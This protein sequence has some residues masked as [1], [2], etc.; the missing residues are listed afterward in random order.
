MEIAKERAIL[1]NSTD[2][3][4]ALSRAVKL[5]L[6]QCYLPLLNFIIIMGT[7]N[8]IRSLHFLT[9][10]QR[11]N[12]RNHSKGDG[13]M[14]FIQTRYVFSEKIGGDCGKGSFFKIIVAGSQKFAKFAIMSFCEE[15][16]IRTKSD[17]LQ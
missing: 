9:N 17:C 16:E 10:T 8:E 5:Q 12:G 11:Y 2:M 1:W 6:N 14:L 15:S 4:R 7:L 3:R 13:C